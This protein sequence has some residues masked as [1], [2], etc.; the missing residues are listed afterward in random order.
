MN[1]EIHLNQKIHLSTLR[2]YS[3]R[4]ASFAEWS[5]DDVN[6]QAAAE[7]RESVGDAIG[8]LTPPS[9]SDELLVWGLS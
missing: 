4:A 2:N 7:G 8:S 1:Q 3:E 9:E 6:S 5:E